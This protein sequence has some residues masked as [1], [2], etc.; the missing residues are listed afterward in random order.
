M[1]GMHHPNSLF[2]SYLHEL[3][4]LDFERVGSPKKKGF[5]LT[6]F[7]HKFLD[8]LLLH[9]II[10]L[11]FKKKFTSIRTIAYLETMISHC[12]VDVKTYFVN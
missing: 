9:P 8:P 4:C 3:T 5:N 7:D 2:Y 10:R 6:L 1:C 12:G 11:V